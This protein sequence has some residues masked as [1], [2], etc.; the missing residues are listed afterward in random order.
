MFQKLGI[1]TVLVFC[2]MSA[3]CY[4]MV[5]PGHV[6]LLIKQTGSDRGVQDYP[7]QTGRVFYNPMNED[8]DVWPTNVQRVIW[9][10]QR[11]GCISQLMLAPPTKCSGIRFLIST[12]SFVQKI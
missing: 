7:I 3:G 11:K 1:S 5:E 6:G 12:S 2:F 9:S 10:A 8:V 4:K